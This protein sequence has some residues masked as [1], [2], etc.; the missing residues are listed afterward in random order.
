MS[1]VG[2][3]FGRLS[4]SRRHLSANSVAVHQAWINSSEK[5]GLIVAFFAKD[6]RTTKYRLSVPCAFIIFLR[7]RL[8][9]ER[10]RVIRCTFVAEMTSA[11]CTS[12]SDVSAVTP[13]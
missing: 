11:A 6:W 12:T 7:E 10:P 3:V 8:L 2:G 1:I 13:R 4:R 9:Q 5:P